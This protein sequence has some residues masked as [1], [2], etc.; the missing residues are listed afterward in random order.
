MAGGPN[1]PDISEVDF[2]N[3][4]KVLHGVPPAREEV[5]DCLF[6]NK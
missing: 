5:E 3:R 2:D 6:S 1:M 4:P